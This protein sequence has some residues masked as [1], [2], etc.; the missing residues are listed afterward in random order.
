DVLRLARRLV[1]ARELAAVDEV[2]V[3]GVG[4]DVAVLFRADRAPVAERDRA[5]V[6]A[7]GGSDRAALLLAAVDPVGK[8]IVRRDVVEL[9]RRLV[10]PTAPR[11]PAVDGE[12]R[13]LVGGEQDDFGVLRINPDGVV[14]VAAGRSL[15]GVVG[16]TAVGRAIGRGVGRINYV[17]VARV[18]L[19]LGEVAAAAPHA[20]LVVDALPRFARV[21]RAVDA[22]ELRRV[23]VR[24]ESL[25]V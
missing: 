24:V 13:A 6:A 5:V 17:G 18:N 11:A 3:R 2:R 19:H 14:V 4:G 9:R 12:R 21:V 20:R 1:E 15:P 16:V 25:R 22:A 23:N 10:V 8:L 7:A